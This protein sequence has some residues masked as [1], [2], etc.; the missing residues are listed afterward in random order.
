VEEDVSWRMVAVAID[1]ECSSVVAREV[2]SWLVVVCAEEAGRDW[3]RQL[4]G[5]T[6]RQGHDDW[7]R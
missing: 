2:I 1:V 3:M 5:A 7:A 6:S 4:R